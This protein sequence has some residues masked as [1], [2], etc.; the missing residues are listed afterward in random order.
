MKYAEIIANSPERICAVDEI[1]MVLSKNLCLFFV[2]ILYESLWKVIYITFATQ[3]ICNFFANEH[4]A[5][6]FSGTMFFCIYFVIASLWIENYSPE[7]ILCVKLKFVE[8]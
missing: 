7:N 3:I 4:R 2:P 5:Q 8:I 1:S 6:F